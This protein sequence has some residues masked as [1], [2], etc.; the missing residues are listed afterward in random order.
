MRKNCLAIFFLFVMAS[1]GAQGVDW[2]WAVACG[3]QYADKINGIAQDPEGNYCVTGYF[4]YMATFGDIVLS[5]DVWTQHMFVAKYDPDGQALWAVCAESTGDC[6]GWSLVCDDDGF[7]YVTGKFSGSISMDGVELTA[8]GASDVFVACLDSEG[9]WQWAIKSSGSGSSVTTP[10]RIILGPNDDLYLCGYFSGMVSLGSETLSSA[11][12]YD[13]WVAKVGTAGNWHWATRAGGTGSDDG[14]S[15]ALLPSGGIVLCGRTQGSAS[16][17]DLSLSGFTSHN[18]YVAW[19]SQDAVWTDVIRIS[20]N[21]E[22]YC[23][24]LAVDSQGNVYVTGNYSDDLQCGH[25]QFTGQWVD[26]FMAKINGLARYFEWV[27]VAGTASDE[28]AAAVSITPDDEIYWA[29]YFLYTIQ[30]GPF[31]LT[32]VSS[33]D[34]FL[35]RLDVNG[36]YMMAEH[37]GNIC[38]DIVQDM[39]TDACGNVCVAGWYTGDM[40]FG[41]NYL[42]FHGDS[43]CF[44]AKM[45]ET[46]SAPEEVPEAPEPKLVNHPNPVR[47]GTTLSYTLNENCLSAELKIY[48]LRGRL[49]RDCGPVSALMGR[50]DLYWDGMD[51][52]GARAAAGVYLLQLKTPQGN[53]SRRMALLR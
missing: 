53:Y 11:G 48:D 39:V 10:R 15:L 29:G 50:H 22:S 4:F 25:Y 46:V 6:E 38:E 30:F 32:Y 36:N 2:Q 26:V 35:V 41:D 47:E 14:N 33:A 16:F 42:P 34:I 8:T 45:H 21:D 28:N 19:L 17:G 40:Y 31:S 7:T 24:D 51:Q 1:L 13:I 23:N 20:S 9:A 43:H 3:G 37:A 52:Q 49:I 5:P 18:G 12:S 44:I 27:R